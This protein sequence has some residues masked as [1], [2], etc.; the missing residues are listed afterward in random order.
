MFENY[1]MGIGFEIISKK[2][3]VEEILD[4]S[5]SFGLEAKKIGR[6]EKSDGENRVTIKSSFGKFSYK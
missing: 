3:K 6:C 1:N 4:I 5:E 2:E